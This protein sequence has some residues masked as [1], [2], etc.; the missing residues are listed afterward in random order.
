MLYA[1]FSNCSLFKSFNSL[2]LRGVLVKSN[3]TGVKFVLNVI[4]SVNPDVHV[5]LQDPLRLIHKRDKAIQL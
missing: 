1:A 2:Y 4:F 3:L 5:K